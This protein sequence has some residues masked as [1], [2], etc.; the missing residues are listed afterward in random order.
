MF[1]TDGSRETWSYVAEIFAGMSTRYTDFI[2]IEP[3]RLLVVYDSVPRGWDP[4]PYSPKFADHDSWN[5]EE[6]NTDLWHIRRR[7]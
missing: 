1:T 7:P 5:K 2:E 3:G 6:N 4:L